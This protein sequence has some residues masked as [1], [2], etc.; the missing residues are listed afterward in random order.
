MLDYIYPMLPLGAGLVGHANE[1]LR[2]RENAA[3][4]EMAQA[5][6]EAGVP[7]LLGVQ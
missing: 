3:W 2:G 5:E 6:A 1:P 7:K 4:G